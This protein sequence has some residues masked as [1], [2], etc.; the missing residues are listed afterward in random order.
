VLRQLRAEKLIALRAG[1]AW[2]LDPEKLTALAVLEP[3]A[4]A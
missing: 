4:G 3:S 2:L 1:L